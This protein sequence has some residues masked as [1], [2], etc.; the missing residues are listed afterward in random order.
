M[1]IMHIFFLNI[2]FGYFMVYFFSVMNEIRYLADW[3]VIVSE[4]DQMDNK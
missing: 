2:V 3:D 1:R 4:I